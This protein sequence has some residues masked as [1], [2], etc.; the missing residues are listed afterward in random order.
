MALWLLFLTGRKWIPAPE[1]LLVLMMLVP[2]TLF[3]FVALYRRHTVPGF[4]WVVPAVILVSVGLMSQ[5]NV[6]REGEPDEIVFT[7]IGISGMAGSYVEDLYSAVKH[8]DCGSEWVDLVSIGS[9][10]RT[11]W[12]GAIDFS[13]NRWKGK[14]YKYAIGVRGYFGQEH[15]GMETDYPASGN[16]A[17]VAPYISFQWRYFGL[18]AGLMLGQNKIGIPRDH[19]SFNKFSDGDII[20]PDH[21]NSWIIPAVTLRG[22]PSDIAF[23]EISFPAAFPSASPYPLLRAGVGSGFGRTDGTRVVIG[24]CDGL[25]IQASYPVSDY[26]V[27]EAF[28]ADRLGSGNQEKRIL[29]VG[30]Q[31]RIPREKK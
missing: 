29:S 17:G 5:K 8:N 7:G 19:G 4:R 10:R 2:L 27:M 15:G 25:F 23:G 28:Y 22:G 1:T 14:Y 3:R 31:V 9:Q 26:L 24:Y 6:G 16:V 11:Y 12:Q 20:A 21:V 18:G 13:H 30:I